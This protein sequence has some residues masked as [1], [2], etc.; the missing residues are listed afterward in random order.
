M[1]RWRTIRAIGLAAA[2]CI[3]AGCNTTGT[4]KSVEA[5]CAARYSRYKDAWA[6]ARNQ[7]AGTYD[8]YRARYLANGDAL[9]DQ[10]SRGQVSDASA[11]DRMSGGFSGGG[12]RR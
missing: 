8:E 1:L 12:G 7:N 6:C 3:L 2:T 9:L 5:D 11:L 4:L 10:V